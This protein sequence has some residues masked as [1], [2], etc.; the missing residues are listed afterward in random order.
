GEKVNTPERE[1]FPFNSDYHAFYLSSEGHFGLGGH[2]VYYVKLNGQGYQGN[3]LNVGKPINSMY[4]DISYVT[5]DGKGYISSNRSVEAEAYDNI[6]AFQEN[7]P[8]KDVY[9]SV[10]HGVVTYGELNTPIEG[11]TVQ[12]LYS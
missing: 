6:Y 4:D 2:D 5:K 7:T 8:I 12:I 9:T 10:P 11:A 1:S 3:L